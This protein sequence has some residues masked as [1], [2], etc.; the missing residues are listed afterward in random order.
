MWRSRVRVAFGF[1]LLTG[2]FGVVNGWRALCLVL[3]AAA[4][5]EAGHWLA[6]RLLGAEIRSLRIGPL[7][8]VLETGAQS[9]SY[10]KELA[11]VLA[12]PGS[13]LLWAWAL[14]LLGPGW[15]APIGAHLVLGVF[16]L[17]PVGPLDGG[18]AVRL[19]LAW[20]WGPAGEEAA[21]WVSAAVA[22][23]AAAGLGVLIWHTGGSLWLLPAM[24]GLLA[25]AAGEL[26]REA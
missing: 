9:L 8:A 5:H 22:L 21:R 12:G 7:G 18:R 2:W 6:L 23:A 10:G 25:A 16:N 24:G 20:R 1:W 17:L 11:A 4:A 26:R 19:I 14:S 15:E 13:N 3:F